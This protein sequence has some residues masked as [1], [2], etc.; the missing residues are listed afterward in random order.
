VPCGLSLVFGASLW[1]DAPPVWARSMLTFVLLCLLARVSYAFNDVGV[2]RLARRQ[3]RM[4]IAAWRGVSLGITMAPWLLWVPR[5]AWSALAGQ[6]VLVLGLVTITAVA[7]L[8]QL[9]AARHL[10]FG[11]RAAVMLGG[12]AVGSAALGA[13]FLGE[14][15]T[16]LQ[17]ALCALLVVASSLAARGKSSNLEIEENVPRGVALTLGSA[18]LMA[19]VALLV[20]RLAQATHPLLAAW[21]WEFGSGLVLMGPLLLQHGLRPNPGFRQRVVQIAFAAAPTAIGSGASVLAL[22][23]GEL[24]LWGALGGTQILFTAALGALL[25]REALG[26]RRW[27]CLGVAAAAV[28]GLALAG[29]TANTPP[30]S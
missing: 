22:G 17:V 23:F 20:K 5:E 3:G 16:A 13:V 26:F 21:S 18:M 29:A 9:Q 4:Q 7:N 8:L 14:Q 15:L 25:Q 11:L 12:M 1:R 2:G 24:G 6:G 28:A 27:L 10:P 19:V 30:H